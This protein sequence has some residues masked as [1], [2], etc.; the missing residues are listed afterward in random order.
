VA[1]VAS[2]DIFPKSALL[3]L[4]GMKQQ[5]AVLAT[6]SDGAVRDVTAEAFIESSNTEVATADK[7]GLVTAIRRGEATLLARYEGNYAAAGLLVMGDRSGFVWKETPEFNAL[8]TLVYEK[9]KQIKI[10]P[11]DLCT[12][13][14]FIR[15]LYLDLTGLPPQ[16]DDVRKFLADAR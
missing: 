10:L 13:A 9:L 4:P 14:E 3:P 2:I 1:R 16:T 7:Q 5:T 6:F 15:R 12:D 8:D 11:S